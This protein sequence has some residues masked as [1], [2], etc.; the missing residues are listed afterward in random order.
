MSVWRARVQW[1]QKARHLLAL[2]V[3]V[4]ASAGLSRKPLGE[5]MRFYPGLMIPTDP[6]INRALTGTTTR[7]KANG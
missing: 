3:A 2:R 7:R 1:E 6:V 5:I 4:V